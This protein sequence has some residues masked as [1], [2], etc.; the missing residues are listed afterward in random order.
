MRK[1]RSN[2]KSSVHSGK[3]PLE[4]NKGKLACQLIAP[5]NKKIALY[6]AIGLYTGLRHS[7]IIQVKKTHLQKKMY[8]IVT[9]KTDVKVSGP[10]PP[11]F[12]KLLQKCGIT[13]AELN[14]DCLFGSIRNPLKTMSYTYISRL[15]KE[16]CV[17][18]GV[19][20]I[21]EIGTHSLRKAFGKYY[22]DGAVD[23]QRALTELC[24][25]FRHD[26]PETTLIYI[27]IMKGDINNRINNFE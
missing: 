23:K 21:D 11:A 10:F 12:Y 16:A 6:M 17:E 24:Q 7:D 1:K 9:E 13:I 3:N 26:E 4:W 5:R 15:L 22:F 8:Y 20:N 18:A 2:S 14:K 25:I 27:G 19:E